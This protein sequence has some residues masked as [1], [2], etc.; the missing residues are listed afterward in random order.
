MNIQ[1][2]DRKLAAYY[3]NAFANNPKI[4]TPI[5]AD[6]TTHVFHQYTLVLID[7]DREGLMK[8]LM[9]KELPLQFT[10]LFHYICKKH[11]LTLDTKKVIS[12]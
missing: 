1:M 3:N 8:H 11:I 10:T 7:V 5:T 12:L 2:H 4:K 9:D 6:F